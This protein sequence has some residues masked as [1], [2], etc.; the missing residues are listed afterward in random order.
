M[1][2]DVPLKKMLSY[3][4]I[5]ISLR[6]ISNFC[7]IKKYEYRLHFD[8]EFLILLTLFNSL[9]VVLINMVATLMMPAKLATLGLLKIN[10]YWIKGYDV[11]ISVH[12]VTKKILSRESNYDVD[13]VM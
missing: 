2:V 1:S 10:V 5:N 13:M 12:D 7:Y 6:E 8:T 11:I 4:G 3:A 9:K